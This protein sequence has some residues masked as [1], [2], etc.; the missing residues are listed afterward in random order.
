MLKTKDGERLKFDGAKFN[1]LMNDENHTKTELKHKIFKIIEKKVEKSDGA[2][3]GIQENTIENWYKLKDDGQSKS[4]PGYPEYV[5]AIAEVFGMD[6]ED[7]VT[8]YIYSSKIPENPMIDEFIEK[9]DSID[10]DDNVANS[11][12]SDTNIVDKNINPEEAVDLINKLPLVRYF[13]ESILWYFFGV[14]L[15]LP[16]KYLLLKKKS[17]NYCDIAD[18]LEELGE[19]LRIPA[20]GTVFKKGNWI[21]AIIDKR[22]IRNRMNFYGI[23]WLFVLTCLKY[24]AKVDI[25][26]H[27]VLGIFYGP[28][29]LSDN[30]WNA[31]M[32]LLD[33]IEKDKLQYSL[34]VN[35]L[36]NASEFKEL[37][38]KEVVDFIASARPVIFP[39][40]YRTKSIMERYDVIE[41]YMDTYR[42][43]MPKFFSKTTCGTGT[44]YSLKVEFGALKKEEAIILYDNGYMGDHMLKQ[45]V[46]AYAY[47]KGIS[48]VYCRKIKN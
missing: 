27:Q 6:Y 16:D 25:S 34:P 15:G 44:L 18:C 4:Q 11:N 13:L 17:E 45:Q 1:M 8:P 20:T 10:L 29:M 5:E 38:E 36:D 35:N 2:I 30:L 48:I 21:Q 19:H 37:S 42:V 47:E 28:R 41:R 31:F 14:G 24:I 43:K 9:D 40:N 46:E 23:D 3:P 7:F 26:W 39:E 22:Y 33:L 32:Y 12:E